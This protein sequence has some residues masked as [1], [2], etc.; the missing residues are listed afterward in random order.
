MLVYVIRHTPVDLPKGY[1]YGQTDVP[2]RKDFEYNLKQISA[3]LPSEF[4][5]VYTSPLQRCQI[6]ANT[7]SSPVVTDPRLMELHFGDW[8]MRT[9]DTIPKEEIDQWSANLEVVSPPNGENLA[10][11]NLRIHDFLHDLRSKSYKKVLIVTHGGPIRCIW[12]Y[13]L[14]FPIEHTFRIPIGFNEV[15]V[16]HLGENQQADYMIQKQ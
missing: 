10:T 1:C 7:F 14:G 15:L 8:E 11:L 5:Q 4:D 3:T 16:F 2:L 9:W 13:L 12:Q 6:L